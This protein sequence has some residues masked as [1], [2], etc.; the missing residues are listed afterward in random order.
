MALKVQAFKTAI[1]FLKLLLCLY[2]FTG[3]ELY[4]YLSKTC[5]KIK[6]SFN[7]IYVYNI[8]LLFGLPHVKRF[9]TF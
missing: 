1:M 3:N 7:K 6:A 8:L 2:Y 4:Y 5:H 9:G